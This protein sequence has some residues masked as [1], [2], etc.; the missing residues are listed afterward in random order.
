MCHVPK[1]I[2]L[3][4]TVG[5]YMFMEGASFVCEKDKMPL[6]FVTKRVEFY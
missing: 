2:F 3:C 5:K 4:P 1:G 6:L